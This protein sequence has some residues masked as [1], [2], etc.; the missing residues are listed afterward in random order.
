MLTLV[1]FFPKVCGD[2]PIEWMLPAASLTEI[3]RV[4]WETH[5][6]WI[7]LSTTYIQEHL[8]QISEEEEFLKLPLAE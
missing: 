7:R 2:Y 5:V 3:L 4:V 8:L 1:Y 6:C